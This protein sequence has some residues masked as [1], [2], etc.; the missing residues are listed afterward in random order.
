MIVNG[1]L[2]TNGQIAIFGVSTW[3]YWLAVFY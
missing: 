2:S 1:Y 3:H